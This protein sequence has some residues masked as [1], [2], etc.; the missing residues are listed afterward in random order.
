MAIDK[1][2]VHKSAKAAATIACCETKILD[3]HVVTLSDRCHH[4]QNERQEANHDS[5]AGLI[6]TAL[7]PDAGAVVIA[8]SNAIQTETFT[9]HGL[10]PAAIVVKA[11]AKR[12]ICH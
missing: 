9:V 3:H 6:I 10:L 7:L 8:E 5:F 11:P 12:P 1:R 4:T 2:A